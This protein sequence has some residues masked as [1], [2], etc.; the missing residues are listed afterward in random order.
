MTLSPGGYGPS[1]F[2]VLLLNLCLIQFSG[3]WLWPSM[4]FG[5]VDGMALEKTFGLALQ[6]PLWALIMLAVY[7]FYVRHRT[8]EITTVL[9]P[10][11]AF[12]LLGCF[13]ALLG[14]DPI[15]SFRLLLL[16]LVAACAAAVIGSNLPQPQ[17]IG[18][19]LKGLLFLLIGSAILGIFL[20]EFG[21]QAYGTDKEVWRGLFTT[22]NQLGWI[23]SIAFVGGIGSYSLAPPSLRHTTIL[24]S[25][26]CLLMSDSAGAL[27]SAIGAIAYWYW[28]GKLPSRFGI[29][30]A[31]VLLLL[32]ITTFLILFQ[33]GLPLLLEAAGR[34][35]T[36]TGR[37]DIWELYFAEM[38]NSPFF[39]EGPGAFT[40]FSPY[41]V[42]LAYKLQEFGGILTP[43]QMYLGAFG[44]SGAIGL[45]VFVLTLLHITLIL[46]LKNRTA[47]FRLSGALGALIMLD[48]LVETHEIYNAGIGFFVMI[49]LLSSAMQNK[50]PMY[51]FGR[52]NRFFNNSSL[53]LQAYK[54]QPL[55]DRVMRKPFS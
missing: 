48:G 13:T 15:A 55:N 38:L 45:V 25:A 34:D 33:L 52:K 39:G 41:T 18:A 28:L 9:A 17:L 16:W 47:I 24:I 32:G 26:L 12:W 27:L 6:Y 19:L 36:L 37:T 50:F 31:I 51:G 22:K 30:N 43:H 40:G 5:G 21:Q 54:Y 49:L 1:A 46:P 7:R 2:T 10:F 8:K 20:P 23:A 4:D 35:S 53:R 44:D 29:G 3:A 14:Y 11:L 42:P